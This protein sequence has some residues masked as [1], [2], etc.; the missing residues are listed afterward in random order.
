VVSPEVDDEA[1]EAAVSNV[2]QFVTG[3]GGDIA[4]EERWG[5][6]RLAYP[7]GHFQEGN[8]VLTRLKMRP[9]WSREL[10]ANLH[11]SEDI[12]RHLLIRVE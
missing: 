7:I 2:K 10:E 11:I 6:R 8:Y 1:L 12:L 9:G 3:R 4:D 5:K